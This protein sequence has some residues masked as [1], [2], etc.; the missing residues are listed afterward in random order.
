MSQA[1]LLARILGCPDRH[2]EFVAPPGMTRVIT[3]VNDDIFRP[4]GPISFYY[5]DFRPD[6][7]EALASHLREP[8][9]VQPMENGK[10]FRTAW[11]VN[12][13]GIIANA[14]SC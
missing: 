1:E 10:T 2:K 8:D 12:E 9:Y 6:E 11:V 3:R 13:S 4:S 14:G 5:Q 7:A